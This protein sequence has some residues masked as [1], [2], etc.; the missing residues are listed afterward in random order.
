MKFKT[1]LILVAVLAVLLTLVLYF[2]SRSEK[3]EAAKEEANTLIDLEA[4]DIRKVSLDGGGRTLAFERDVDGPW[5]LTS[6]LEA[7]ADEYEV[8]RLVDDLASLRIE[9]VVE[10]EGGDAAAYEIPR[11]EISIWVKDKA[12]PVRLLVGMENPLDKTLFAKREDDPRIVLLASTL[13]TTL[14]KPIFDFRQKD[15]FKFTAADVQRVR[16]KA[17]DVEWGAAREGDA[18]SLETPVKALAAKGKIDSLLNDLSGLRAKAF[19]A[20][21]KTPAALEE[22]GLDSPDYEVALSVPAA[23]REILFRLHAKGEASYATSSLSTKIITFEGTLLADLGREVNELR[24]KKVADFYAWNA[25]RVALKRDGVEIAAA[26]TKVDEAEKWIFEDQAGGEADR[27]K[28]ED[29]IRKIESLEAA[30]FIDDPAPPASYGLDPGAEISIRTK[31]YQDQEAEI[32]LLVGREDQG[33][34]LV[35]VKT[36]GLDYLFLVDPAFLQDWPAAREDWAAATPETKESQTD[37]K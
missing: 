2:D 35:P 24:E 22:F 21:D 4:D 18:W 5:R 29:F 8:D 16:V 9:R 13:K 32:V 37:K 27:T 28:I 19:V 14:D 3:R 26:K 25:V 7:A 31:D 17:K 6:P 20:E 11:T 36:P 12:E 23:D 10:A 1:T 34:K 33:R 15:V 30:S